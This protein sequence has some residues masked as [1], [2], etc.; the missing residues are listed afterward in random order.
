MDE[1]QERQR[2]V[3]PARVKA[4][5]IAADGIIGRL[6]YSPAQVGEPIGQIRRNRAKDET[7]HFKQVTPF[8][9]WCAPTKVGTSPPDDMGPFRVARSQKN[10][11]TEY[12]PESSLVDEDL[13]NLLLEEIAA[14]QTNGELKPTARTPLFSVGEISRVRANGSVKGHP[15]LAVASGVSGHVV[16][17]INLSP[18][19]Q[20]WVGADIRVRLRSPNPDLGGGWQCI[21]GPLCLIKFIDDSS[22]HDHIRWLIVSNGTYTTVYEPELRMIPMPSAGAMEK[23]SALPLTTQIFEN[24][25]FTIHS[26]RTGGALQSDVSFTRHFKTG[27]PQLAIVDQAGFWSLWDI[28][29]RRDLRP[30]SLV[31]VLRMCGNTVSGSISRLPSYPTAEPEP[32]NVLYLALKRKRS[33]LEDPPPRRSLLLSCSKSLHLFDLTTET[34][35]SFTN[36]FLLKN[37]HRILGVAPSRLD[38]AQAFI[39][40]STSLFWVTMKRGKKDALTLDVLASCPHQ[41]DVNDSTLRLD[42]SPGTYINNVMACFACIRSTRDAEMT[43]LWFIQPQRGTPVRYHRDLVSLDDP[44]NFVGLAI[45]PAERRIGMEPTTPAGRLLQ[46]AQ[47]R[48]FQLLTLGPDLDVHSA[49]CAWSDDATVSVPP[50]DGSEVLGQSG[51]RRRKLLQTLTDAFAVPDQFDEKAVFGKGLAEELV[52]EKLEGGIQL[53]ADLDLIARHLVGDSESKM[54]ESQAE[55]NNFGFIGKAV[56]REATDGYMPRRSLLDL[57]RFEQPS[58][59]FQLARA[60]D[61][62]QDVQHRQADGWLFVPE[63][64]RPLNDFGPDDLVEKLENLFPRPSKGWAHHNRQNMLRTMAAEMSLSNVGISAVPQ[65]WVQPEDEPSSSLPFPASPSLMPSQPLLP[66]FI[67][68][69]KAKAEAQAQEEQGDTV[70]LRLRKYLTL[71]TSPTIHGEPTLALSRWDLGA[72]PDD[73]TWKPGQDL[74][75]EDAINKRRRKAEARRR[76]AERLSQRVFGEESSF[77]DHSSQS[78]GAPIIVPTSARNSSQMTPQPQI[79]TQSQ[80]QAQIQTPRAGFPW[81]FSSQRQHT[82]QLGTRAFGS[83]R[84]RAGSPLRKEYRQGSPVAATTTAKPGGIFSSSQASQGPSQGPSQGTPSQARSQLIPG[85]FGGRPSLSPF[86]KAVLKKGK[87]KSESR[88]GGFR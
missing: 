87:R 9:Q 33:K 11:L 46:N 86:K 7:P 8:T 53:S 17:L 37:N 67:K 77:M 42:V 58:D 35:G 41:R 79:Q 68:K 31:P 3:P 28:T 70:V 43:V 4:R 13:E 69:G 40:T 16:R 61:A 76:K 73:I 39:L 55:T 24:A 47:L 64:R 52:L 49:L 51:N 18:E 14:T 22:A 56:G 45:L 34:L 60:W 1:R 72:D 85:L 84:P 48:F 25:L 81:D 12:L 75:A 20:F 83:P 21:G 82:P 15:T 30:R 38:P 54:S 6:T 2:P 36:L 19:E 66:S 29:G 26:E 88:L 44:P 5:R 80:P 63:A 32:H 57:A 74:E 10:W 23:G 65:S 78:F 71:D 59:L 62:Q 50:P 27:M